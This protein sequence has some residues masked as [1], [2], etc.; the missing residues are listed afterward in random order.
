MPHQTLQR[1]YTW[2][3]LVAWGDIAEITIY[4]DKQGK[5]V[6]FPKTYPDK[7]P[8]D[9]QVFQRALMTAGA[10]AWQALP[11]TD[12]AQWHLAARRASLVMHGYD[13]FQHWF[14]TRDTSAIRTLERQTRTN[15]LP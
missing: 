2:L 11:P 14:L 1:L 9:D 10:A 7:P 13:L 12:Q 6:W 4:K 5:M 15:L 3:G 8:S